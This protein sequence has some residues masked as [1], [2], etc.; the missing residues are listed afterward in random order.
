MKKH[1]KSCLLTLLAALL[2]SLVAPVSAQTIF[3]C[4]ESANAGDVI[5]L[6]GDSFGNAPQVWFHFVSGTET[7]LTPTLPLTVL[8]ATGSLNATGSNSFVTAKIPDNEPPGL[9]ALWVVTSSGTSPVVFINQ[10]M[11]WN[12]DDLCGSAVDP[13]R[14]FHLYGRNLQ[15]SGTGTPT[16]SFVS[17]SSTLA[18]TVTSGTD[19]C[20]LSVKAPLGVQNGVNYTLLVNNGFGGSYGTVQGPVLT[21]TVTTSGT[22]TNPDPFGIG[23]PWCGDFASYPSHVYQ[24]AAPTGSGTTDTLNIQHAIN[25]VSGSGGGIVA[26]QSGTY[27]AFSGSSN[28]CLVMATG[29]VIEGT[30]TS[31]TTST[32][33]EMTGTS[34]YN[35]ITYHF[36]LNDGGLT[37]IDTGLINL[38]LYNS[39]TG[40]ASCLS[41]GHPNKDKFFAVN[42][43][44]RSDVSYT[45][46]MSGSQAVFK[47]CTVY[48]GTGI[49]V[50]GTLY[51]PCP[52]NYFGVTDSVM[53]NDFFQYYNGRLW[54]SYGC[55][56]LLVLSNT[57]SRIA[58]GGPI[59][60]SGGVSVQG[61]Q[62][63]DVLDNVIQRDPTLSGTYNFVEDNSGESILNQG[64][65]EYFAC[66]GDVS[67][68]SSNTLTD[69]TRNWIANVYSDPA[70][71]AYDI[72]MYYATI[73]AG[74]GAGQIREVISNTANTL[75]L[76][77]PWQVLPTSNSVY[78]VQHLESL[79]NLIDGNS[80]TN[81]IVGI[82]YYTVGMKDTA[83]VNNSL[84]NAGG[85]YLLS[86]YKPSTTGTVVF[87]VQFDTLV[88]NNTV[89]VTSTDPYN[90]ADSHA[91][92]VDL[93]EDGGS[94]GTPGTQAFCPE[95]RG[96]TVTAPVPNQQSGITGEGFSILATT[97]SEAAPLADGTTVV[98]LAAVFQNNTAV[99]CSN[100]F[101]LCTGDYYTAL[102]NNTYTTCGALLWN[103]T[104]AGVAYGAFDTGYG[105]L[106]G[107]WDF[108]SLN[109]ADASGNGNNGTMVNNPSFSGSVPFTT[110]GNTDSI[111][112][113]GSNYVQ[114]PNSPNTNPNTEMTIA[115][116]ICSGT[117]GGGYECAV[118][119]DSFYNGWMI[120][121]LS[122]SAYLYLR[123][124]T[125]AGT[126]QTPCF[127]NNVYTNTWHFIAFVL[128]NGT[129]K[130]Y[131]D[132]SLQ[133][134]GTYLV[135]D[136]FSSTTNLPLTI[137]ESAV[138]TYPMTGL[139]DEVQ[140]YDQALSA[141]QISEIMDY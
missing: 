47:N 95:F 55:S 105:S 112:F 126:G 69:T 90:E 49:M 140:I 131:M 119:K 8:S 75:T 42:T 33:I 116:W 104:G 89:T 100:A 28:S 134:T 139:M 51:G 110:N 102:W 4:P 74:P 103:G 45:I 84:Y 111:S 63:T 12:A 48:S 64:G 65:P 35:P 52:V 82:Q 20:V 77:A 1:N 96:N 97:N 31:G 14:Q 23:V 36:G 43:N 71:F 40:G 2:G 59:G 62:D 66:V 141:S 6:Q 32:T 70:A 79:R 5:A 81:G 85:I 129:V 136:G 30:G 76:S 135:G 17:T 121:R 92:I 24:V 18:A 54:L 124:D 115:F 137:G 10:A 88:E 11:P 15:F 29:V 73:I 22:G 80:L 60:E 58:F 128:N 83:I 27:V 86:A 13:T 50:S 87:N 138:G 19:S 127:I 125:S 25:A 113:T 9:Y 123:V 39:P 114:I 108:D 57:I 37:L 34:I 3:N 26:L 53:Q 68:S 132:G 117:N 72:G 101:H 61:S 21:G 56:G 122:T 106:T 78:A 46:G 133:S 94:P 93:L 118:G 7:S 99:S 109:A 16:V 130:A 44:F 41:F 120:Q 67:S 98:A 38:T 91:Y 107:F